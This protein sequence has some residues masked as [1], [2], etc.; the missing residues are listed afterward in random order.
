[1]VICFRRGPLWLDGLLYGKRV[2]R[3]ALGIITWILMR[4]KAK[5][6]WN[7]LVAPMNICAYIGRHI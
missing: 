1:M 4:S 6:L 5:K 3:R 2:V 7:G